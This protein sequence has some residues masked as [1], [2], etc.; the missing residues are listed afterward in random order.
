MGG[1]G[2]WRGWETQSGGRLG[3]V[4][5]VLDLGGHV[6]GFLIWRLSLSPFLPFSLARW[7]PRT[8]PNMMNPKK[9]PFS[10]G[11]GRVFAVFLGNW[12]LGDD[13]LFH[14]LDIVELKRNTGSSS[15]GRARCASF[16]WTV[17]PASP[18]P[19]MAR[20]FLA[21]MVSVVAWWCDSM[22]SAMKAKNPSMKTARKTV[23]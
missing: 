9:V 4:Q 15:A 2:L 23:F 14:R 22:A 5:W 11:Q 19:I 1:P 6:G 18:F 20:V 21:W 7:I 10:L 16:R 8:P 3:G 17:R 12:D 13:L